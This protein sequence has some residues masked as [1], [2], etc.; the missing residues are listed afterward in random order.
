[1]LLCFH[2]IYFFVIFWSIDET[3]KL[4]KECIISEHCSRPKFDHPCARMRRPSLNKP[5]FRCTDT[6]VIVL[7]VVLAAASNLTLFFLYYS[8]HPYLRR[9]SVYHLAVYFTSF[10]ST[11]LAVREVEVRVVPLSNYSLTST[12]LATG[13][14]RSRRGCRWQVFSLSYIT[15]WYWCDSL[16]SLQINSSWISD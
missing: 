4:R 9:L 3:T 12:S 8:M 10:I 16:L 5:H 13:P 15:P 14:R 2:F 7:N 1:M 6:Y 11:S